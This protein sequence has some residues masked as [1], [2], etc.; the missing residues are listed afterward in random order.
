[1]NRIREF[2]EKS[3]LTQY[4]LSV[5]LGVERTTVTKWETG[6]MLPRA[7]KLPSLARLLGCTIDDLYGNETEVPPMK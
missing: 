2:R 6:R 5:E 4:E 1:M 3:K 7:D